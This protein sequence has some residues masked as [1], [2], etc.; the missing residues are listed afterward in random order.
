MI[1]VHTFGPSAPKHNWYF[2]QTSNCNFNCNRREEQ[3]E[4]APL[5]PQKKKI[6]QDNPKAERSPANI[7]DMK[8]A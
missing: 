8:G 4:R 5:P 1:H 6:L 7:S 3:V 2:V